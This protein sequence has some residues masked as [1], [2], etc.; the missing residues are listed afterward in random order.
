MPLTLAAPVH[1]ELIIKKSRFIGCVQ[2]MADRASAQKVVAGLWAQH[3]GARHV[4]WALLAGGQSAAVD[5]GEPSGTAGRP[6][7]DVL[8]HQDLEGVLATVVRYFGGVKLGAGGLVRAYTDA[9][10][11][12]LLTATKVPIVRMRMLGCTVPY[13]LEGML[14]RELDA[15]G[16]ALLDVA[17]GQAVV[18][19]FSLAEDAAA[20][21]VS[22]LNELGQGRLAWLDD[23][24]ASGGA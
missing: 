23:L 13:A 14:R 24:D 21:L 10:A 18:L 7:L 4:C 16:A 6:M 15:A 20:A 1:S 9:V 19:R 12:A 22:R 11:Q 3:P 17:H 2:P 5:D 8:R